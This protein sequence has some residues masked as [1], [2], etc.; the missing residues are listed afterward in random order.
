[1][2]RGGEAAAGPV[3]ISSVNWEWVWEALWA[4]W[5][6]LSMSLLT[7]ISSAEVWK[8]KAGRVLFYYKSR[9]FFRLTL[10][11]WPLAQK[12]YLGHLLPFKITSHHFFGFTSSSLRI[13]GCHVKD[14]ISTLSAF[15]EVSQYNFV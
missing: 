13:L 10:T 15:Q 3:G 6:V 9:Q 11:Y 1:M 14:F 12:L 2:T 4:F 7:L 8:C 5:D